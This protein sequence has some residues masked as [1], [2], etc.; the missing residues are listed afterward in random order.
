MKGISAKTASLISK[1]LAVLIVIGGF[2]AKIFGATID[3]VNDVLPTA[4]GIILIFGTV[5]INI[6]A[7]KF[8]AKKVGTVEQVAKE[9]QKVIDPK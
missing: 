5:D 9:V 7:E 3:I 8:V 6:L 4:G 1:I 2:V